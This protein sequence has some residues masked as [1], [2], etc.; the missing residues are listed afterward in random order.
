MAFSMPG[1]L[2]SISCILQMKE[3]Q[4]EF[5]KQMDGTRKYHP[6]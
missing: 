5:C 2:S 4:P 3:K 6:A 1:I